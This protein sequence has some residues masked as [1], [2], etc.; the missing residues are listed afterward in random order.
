MRLADFIAANREPI[1]AEWEAFARTC[2]PAGA[3]MDIAGLRDHADE[4]LTVIAADLRTP[5]SRSEQAEKSR[6]NAPDADTGE[7][8]AAEEHGAGRAE[9][10][11][12]VEQMVAEY[13]ALRASVIRLWTQARGELTPADVGDLTRFHEAIDQ[14]LAESI[15]R[16]TQDLDRSKQM[17]LAILGHDLRT[18]LGAILTSARFMLDT[19]ELAEPHLTL[20]S[21]IV[22]SAT[23]MN[24]M[25][26]DLLDF[27][28]SRLGGGIPIERAEMALGK[29]VHEVVDEISAAHPHR[30]LQV[31]ARGEQR[32]EWDCERVSQALTN[33]IANAV[34]HGAEGTTVTVEL[35]GDETEATIAIHNRG[36]PIPADQLDGIFN[37]MKAR[38]AP[39]RAAAG[40]P[41]GSLGLGLYIAERIV[42]AHNGRIDVESSEAEGTTFTVHLPRRG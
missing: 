4:M 33:L 30:R 13:R 31:Q 12:S 17:F 24:Q 29:V 35:R 28:R 36:R 20:T 26:G 2:A 37:P 11:F 16:Y 10:G 27:T 1:L 9:S 14:S 40:G 5:Q 3:A 21:R 38:E 6:G 22:S 32:G 25:V 18:P 39:A 8:T 23:R 19:R 7:A 34:Q 41:T 42:T 15:S